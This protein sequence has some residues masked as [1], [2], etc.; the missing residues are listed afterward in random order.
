MLK[1][2][3]SSLRQSLSRERSTNLKPRVLLATRTSIFSTSTKFMPSTSPSRGRPLRRSP[4]SDVSNG[5]PVS[6]SPSRPRHSISPRSASRS[7]RRNGRYRSESR[8]RSRSISHGRSPS[9]VRSTKV[10]NQTLSKIHTNS[11]RSSSR[12]SQRMS[13]KT[14]CERSLVLSV[15]FATWTCQ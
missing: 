7:P 6:R 10:R 3:A 11:G 4:Y 13:M 2:Y 14:I 12:S 1:K 8:S 9:P 15:K 5:R